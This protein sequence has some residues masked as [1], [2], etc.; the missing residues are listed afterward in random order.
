MYKFLALETSTKLNDI[1]CVISFRFARPLTTFDSV[2]SEPFPTT[3]ISGFSVFVVPLCANVFKHL[4]PGIYTITFSNNAG[5]KK[6]NFIKTE[7]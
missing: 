2:I 7:S 6:F 4:A 3:A 5:I 1:V